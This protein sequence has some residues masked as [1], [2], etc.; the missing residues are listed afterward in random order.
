[1]S[2]INTKKIVRLGMWNISDSM[3]GKKAEM[4]RLQLDYL[5]IPK[6]TKKERDWVQIKTN[7]VMFWSKVEKDSTVKRRV[8]LITQ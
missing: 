4:V 7:Y 2:K 3:S 8:A 5:E 1:M 6:I